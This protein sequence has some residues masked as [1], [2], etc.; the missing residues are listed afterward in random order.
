MKTYELTTINDVLNKVPADRIKDCLTE[1]AEALI[2]VALM[3]DAMQASADALGLGDISGHIK[4][5]DSHTWLDDGL[6][7]VSVHCINSAGEELF[8]VKAGGDK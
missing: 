2:T 8:S 6:G 5:P 4:L 7:N 3:R 1:L